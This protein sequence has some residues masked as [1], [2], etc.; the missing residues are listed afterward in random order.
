MT[1]TNQQRKERLL[2]I[3]RKVAK[4]I[5]A[6]TPCISVYLKGSLVRDEIIYNSDIDLI[7][8]LHNKRYF[9]KLKKYE[10]EE[11][12][13]S[14]YTLRELETGNANKDNRHTPPKA[15][16]YD[17]HH[18]W[19]LEGQK[20]DASSFP[21]SDPL[22]R[23]T[24]MPLLVTRTINEYKKYQNGFGNIIKQVLWLARIELTVKKGIDTY[25]WKDVVKH[26]PKNHIY[27]KAHQ[28]RLKRPKKRGKR[29]E[30]FIEK[31][32]DHIQNMKY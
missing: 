15:T 26:Y 8:I 18:F 6:E 21:K 22:K 27:R 11:V 23:L 25:A 19:R 32:E 24:Y 13:I 10:D 16:N 12:H 1:E 2:T 17:F 3:A 14:R 29:E 30:A 28:Y 31:V 7:V 20:I 4:K 5:Y 9:E